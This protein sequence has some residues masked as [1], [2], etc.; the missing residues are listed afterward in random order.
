MSFKVR[1]L[2]GQL[3]RVARMSLNFTITT[4]IKIVSNSH[5]RSQ[6]SQEANILSTRTW[7]RILVLPSTMIMC[8]CAT[9]ISCWGPASSTITCSFQKKGKRLNCFFPKRMEQRQSM[10]GCSL[11]GGIGTI[12]LS[13]K[14]T[15]TEWITLRLLPKGYR[16]RVSSSAMKMQSSITI[17]SAFMNY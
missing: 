6:P 11:G 15:R 10:P 14:S 5:H 9:L 8:M 3:R 17:L 1:A 13:S 7:S 12:F 2:L 16:E 4:N